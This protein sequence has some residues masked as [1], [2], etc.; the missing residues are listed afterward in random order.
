MAE[1]EPILWLTLLGTVGVL[2]GTNLRARELATA[3]ARD[4][5]AREQLQF[6]DGT[7]ALANLRPTV[8]RGRL[9]WRRRYHFEFSERGDLRRLGCIE[10]AG[11]TLKNLHLEP[12]EI[13]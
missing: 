2:W 8:E 7:V 10:L 9:C 11:L 3:L 1:M 4:Y 13:V 5:C 6:L 12:Y